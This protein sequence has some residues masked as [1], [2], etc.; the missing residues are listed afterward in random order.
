MPTRITTP[1]AG[2]F[3]RTRSPST[4]TPSATPTTGVRYVT[5]DDRAAPQ[6][7]TSR[8]F[9]MNATPVPT[10]PSASIAATTLQSRATGPD[11][12]NGATTS[13]SPAA[14]VS[15][16][17]ERVG[18]SCPLPATNRRRYAVANP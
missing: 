1:P 6:A 17:A 16:T 7:C 10:H 3:H 5:V 15:C 12:A 4:A 18:A 9:Q 2:S 11:A 14:S 13:I 8:V